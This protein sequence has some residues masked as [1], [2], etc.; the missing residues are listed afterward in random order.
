MSI[1]RKLWNKTIPTNS[2]LF[3]AGTENLVLRILI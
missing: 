3:T 2:L 1:V